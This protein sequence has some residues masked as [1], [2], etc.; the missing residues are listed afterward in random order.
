MFGRN[1]SLSCF[2]GV[3]ILFAWLCFNWPALSTE[4]VQTKLL[5]AFTVPCLLI[6]FLFGQHFIGTVYIGY[7]IWV[8]NYN[9]G[10][11]L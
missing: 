11:E 8:H 10:K 1:S 2:V 5:L 6:A 9:S 7:V 4:A 3:V